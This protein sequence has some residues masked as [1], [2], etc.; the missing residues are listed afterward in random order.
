MERLRNMLLALSML[1]KK[2]MLP[3]KS[4]AVLFYLLM[5]T[6]F[7]WL[8]W[9]T[10][11]L[12]LQLADNNRQLHTLAE[13]QRHIRT[14][15]VSFY[16][17][18]T[19]VQRFILTGNATHLDAAPQQT[20]SLYTALD[21]ISHLSQDDHLQ[22]QTVATIKNGVIRQLAHQQQYI[23]QRYKAG[24]SGQQIAMLPVDNTV[25]E[26]LTNLLEQTRTGILAAGD[27]QTFYTSRL[28]LPLLL[29][30]LITLLTL[31][32]NRS[33]RKRNRTLQDT[34]ARREKRFRSFIEEAQVMMFIAD[35]NGNFTYVNKKLA[36]TS[37]YTREELIGRHYSIFLDADT[38]ERLRIA[39]T[40]QYVYNKPH[41]N[42]EFLCTVKTGERKWV[43]QHLTLYRENGVVKG[44]QAIVKDIHEQK[45]LKLEM[46][47]LA[48]RQKETQSRLQAIL[49]YSTSIIFIKDLQGRYLL[50]NKPFEE[51]NNLEPGTAIGYTDQD[52]ASNGATKS[53]NSDHVVF[54]KQQ[55][56]KVIETV[57]VNGAERHIFMSR[58]PL[59]NSDQEMFGICGIGMDI[60]ERVIYEREVI[61]ARKMAEDAKQVQEMFMANMSHEIRTPIN[62]IMGMAY[63]LDRSPVNTR[64]QEYLDG[65]KDAS[66]NLLVIINDILDFSKM[67]AGKM[68]LE[69][70][71]INIPSLVAKEV[72]RLKP[73]ADKKGVHLSYYTDERIPASLTGD[74]VRIS[75]ILGNL[76][77][78]AIK[79]TAQ[80]SVKV[81]A[82]LLET[83]D[84]N[85]THV[86]FEVQDTGIG[87]PAEKQ[88]MIFE[89]FTQTSAENTR[90]Y[91]GTGLGLAICKAL[92]TMQ[93][94]YIAVK[95]TVSKGAT[96]YVEIP[97]C[98]HAD[99][100]QEQETHAG[101]IPENL[102]LGK[103]LLLA[104]D[105]TLN[106]KVAYYLLQQ[107]GASVDI[108][109]NGRIA[110]Q[111][112]LETN[113][114]CVLMDIQMPEMDGYQ[115]TTLI[116]QTG[117][118]IPI[119]AM[120]A[121]A[122][123]GEE[124]KC[125]KAGMNDYV[126]K[127]FTPEV[128]FN[129]ILQSTGTPVTAIRPAA[130]VNG[131]TA[132]EGLTDL[133]YLHTLLKDDTIYVRE[134]LQDFHDTLPGIIEELEQA[135]AL[136][137]WELIHYLVHRLKSSLSIVRIPTAMELAGTL[138]ENA[139][140]RQHLNTLAAQVHQLTAILREAC[141]EVAMEI[142]NI[143]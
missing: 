118:D 32:A 127:P 18:E 140:G 41:T 90:R 10:V 76:I 72:M 48:A 79:F 43:E 114:D 19:G 23:Q 38:V 134:L 137:Q 133:H 21:E 96:F 119:I 104:E 135:A 83:D 98:S 6:L 16:Q 29:G 107:A 58:F 34:M 132:P 109:D 2:W 112:V 28:R 24:N 59:F 136:E 45:Q 61:A 101:P 7:A 105:N 94:G 30:G 89:S 131:H 88:E 53:G 26:L 103:K 95:S 12:T 11:D 142:E 91:G 85:N 67:Q 47:R 138:E 62:G 49:D 73:Q 54:E 97:F 64:Q 125:L 128:L 92:V 17:L 129:K 9:Y 130:P 141:K 93:G 74:A 143:T 56:L 84:H 123:A 75:Q 82:R 20:A 4:S 106:Q 13:K 139:L 5:L 115:T 35:L 71:R 52:L 50:A 14:V 22:L 37:G 87:I 65:I 100:E 70:V 3:L 116:R 69:K 68:V 102:L 51:I 36:E 46:E 8:A 121:S 86:G 120:T 39:Y 80:G 81:T 31:L 44:F 42:H 124:E 33:Y 77:D 117:S 111:R 15:Q 60:T 1:L 55:P 27:R 63:L 66:R 40:E 99:A 122:I 110:L 126:S 113:Y 78:N 108:A 57:T 25:D